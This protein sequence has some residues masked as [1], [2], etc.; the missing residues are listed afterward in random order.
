M[1]GKIF[2]KLKSF[3]KLIDNY[4]D[5][6]MTF[7]RTQ[8][9]LTSLGHLSPLLS[10]HPYLPSTKFSI[11]PY[12]IQLIINDILLHQ[13]KNVVEIGSGV[14]TILLARL[15]K[16]NDLGLNIVSIDES[17]EWQKNVKAQLA[18]ENLA[19]GIMWYCGSLEEVEIK[20]NERYRWFNKKHIE[21]FLRGING[22]VDVLIVDG[23]T[24]IHG[25][26]RYPALPVIFPYLNLNSYAIFL[27]DAHRSAEKEIF[28]RW[29]KDFSVSG[30]IYGQRIGGILKNSPMYISP[31]WHSYDSVRDIEKL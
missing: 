26:E 23:P 17:P 11:T 4:P 6:R 31:T 15:N 10:N 19:E 18:K 8:D 24:T 3:S 7:D 28:K 25:M 20:S 13:R 1:I 22:S 9:D 21:S 30:K 16:I 14:L 27:D 12:G 29:C 2:R 5:F